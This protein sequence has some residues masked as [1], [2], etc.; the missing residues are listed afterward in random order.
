MFRTYRNPYTFRR[1]KRDRQVWKTILWLFVALVGV[2][3]AVWLVLTLAGQRIK[4][5]NYH[6]QPAD[7]YAY[8]LQTLNS[9]GKPISGHR[10]GQLQVQPSWPTGFA[11]QNEQSSEY[12]TINAQGFRYPETLTQ[13]KPPE[14]IRIFLV[15]SSTAFGQ[16]LGADDQTI[17]ARLERRL[18]ERLEQQKRSPEKYKPTVL[19]TTA[20]G[21]QKIKDLPQRLK[22]GSYRVINAAVPGY[23]SGNQLA[24]VALEILPY[25]PDAIIVMNG[26][27]DLMLSSEQDIALLQPITQR[28]ERPMHG[29]WQSLTRPMRQSIRNTN[30]FKAVQ[31]YLLKP[32]PSLLEQSL[33]L[34]EPSAQW[35]NHLPA[36]TSELEQRIVRYRQ[37]MKQLI[38]LCAGANVPLVI[39][40]QPELTGITVENRQP[41][42]TAIATTLPEDYA[43]IIQAGY[44]QLNEVNKILGKAFPKNV[45]VL[46][47]YRLFNDLSAVAFIDTVNLTEDGTKAIAERFYNAI[48]Q[49]PQL[50]S[51]P[52]K[53]NTP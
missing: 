4:L 26:Y 37:H 29:A 1:K 23:T 16:G 44:G 6:G 25:Q 20:E 45:K 13:E 51:A 33:P 38:Q 22:P 42:E 31:F 28:L 19:P 27:D 40:L 34:A 18:Q 21:L 49:L 43:Q 48:A 12:W 3:V 47:H 15:G 10:T 39:G 53:K 11:L 9:E 5:A 7:I 36:D 30:T 52:A 50:Q 41:A 2:E 32:Q 35:Q 17:A 8:Q 24:Q 46:N 14:E